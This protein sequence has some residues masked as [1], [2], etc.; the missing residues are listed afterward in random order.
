[1]NT[2]YCQLYSVSADTETRNMAQAFAAFLE[3]FFQ[4]NTQLHCMNIL[5]IPNLFL[6]F[7]YYH[8]TLTDPNASYG[9][10]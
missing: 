4:P 6:V 10:F 2:D 5:E 8:R 1:M 9:K 3:L 7:N